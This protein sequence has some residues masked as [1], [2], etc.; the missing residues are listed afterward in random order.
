MFTCLQFI[1]DFT[2][3]CKPMEIWVDEEHNLDN[4]TWEQFNSKAVN[5]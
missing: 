1:S 5:Y 4:Q 2:F 3:A